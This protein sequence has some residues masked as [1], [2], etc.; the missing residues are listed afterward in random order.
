MPQGLAVPE[1]QTVRRM[2]PAPKPTQMYSRRV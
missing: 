2:D 1:C